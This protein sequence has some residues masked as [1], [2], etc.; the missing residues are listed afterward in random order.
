MTFMAASSQE[1]RNKAYG[2]YEDL[3][4]EVGKIFREAYMPVN[5]VMEH[6]SAMLPFLRKELGRLRL[7][8]WI[9]HDPLMEVRK[10][11]QFFY[12]RERGVK[13]LVKEMNP[14]VRKFLNRQNAEILTDSPFEGRD[15]HDGLVELLTRR[16][17]LPADGPEEV[18]KE[19]LPH[20]FQRAL[21]NIPEP[22]LEDGGFG[23]VC[24]VMG[25]VFLYALTGLDGV[26]SH[27]V[28][29]KK[30]EQA[31][32]GGFYF[33]MFYPLID[34]IM[35]HPGVFSREEKKT[36]LGQ[37]D[38]WIVGDFSVRNEMIS[39]PS[40]V[41]LE[42]ILKEF[43]SLFPLEKYPELYQ[44]ALML[45]FSQIEDG[46]KT[47]DQPYSTEELYVPVI[48]KA[49][50]TRILAAFI[51]GIEV[52]GH[53]REHMKLV[54]LN[55]QLM[56]DFRDWSGDHKSRQFTPFTY[57]LSGP[58][59]QEIN[60]FSLYLASLRVVFHRFKDDPFLVNLFM[61]RLAI[62]VQRLGEDPPGEELNGRMWSVINQ[63]E[64]TGKIMNKIHRLDFRIFDPDKEFTRPVDHVVNRGQSR[65]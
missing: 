8:R 55:L 51:S 17:I 59:G 47:L 15:L 36:L 27:Q 49:A 60:P 61:R 28:A 21:D 42:E 45:Y 10:V 63:N 46:R 62:S 11:V 53:L 23:K 29:R 26:N 25:G 37:L 16:L 5:K 4:K 39:F 22:I 19:W 33:G 32:K 54:G 64:K 2:E 13:V 56:D 24:R 18:F 44:A 31:V 65:M 50:Y 57:Y 1:F 38:H 58:S 40:V 12:S 48:I 14:Y 43:H 34:D 9:G 41:L 20:Q 30:M 7:S 52:N 35:D 3:K 6:E